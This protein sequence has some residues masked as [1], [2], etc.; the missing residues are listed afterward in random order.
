MLKSKAIELLGGT[1]PEAA[2][3]INVSYQAVDKWPDRLPPRIADRVIAAVA[4]MRYPE[5]A[6]AESEEPAAFPPLDDGG[7]HLAH[8]GGVGKELKRLR[9]VRGLTLEQ[10]S[11]ISGVAVGT[12]SAL[13]NRDSSRSQYFPALARALG[14]TVEEL[15]TTAADAFTPEQRLLH[16]IRADYCG[17]VNAELARRI[18]I[19]E[20][21]VGRLFYPA[22]KPGRKGVGLR[23]MR[24]CTEAFKL[25][26]GFWEGREL[27]DR[28]D[29]LRDLGEKTQVRLL[30][31]AIEDGDVAEV[32]Q[33]LAIGCP[34]QHPD[35]N[36]DPLQLAIQRARTPAG[37]EIIDA[38]LDAGAGG[39]PDE[40]TAPASSKASLSL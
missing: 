7:D 5:L 3:A 12:I 34:V 37:R 14:T 31:Q 27:T 18:G 35:V 39:A 13:E 9:Q 8:P 4:R 23:V 17:G 2:A 21:Y 6:E 29:A 15:Q 28:T 32:R 38:L 22:G 19:D 30:L 40:P 24:A 36:K 20:T 26:S 16:K 33:L 10:L 25:P 11:E 1:I